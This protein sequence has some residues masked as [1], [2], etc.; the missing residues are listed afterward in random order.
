[1]VNAAPAIWGRARNP[2]L[3]DPNRA[4]VDERWMDWPGDS[5]YPSQIKDLGES[6][7]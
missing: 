2:Q 7:V 6:H 3:I 4:L 5:N 1:M